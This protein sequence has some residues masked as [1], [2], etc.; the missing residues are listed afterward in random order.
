MDNSWDL[1]VFK[2]GFSIEITTFTDDLVEFDMVGIDPPLANAF[3]RILISEVPTVAI[4]RVTV[5]QNT[6]VIHDENLAH[7]LGLIPIR[8][9]PH[10][11]EWKK[12]D[13]E[14]DGS[15]SLVF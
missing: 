5:Y 4:S 3:R 15:N 1:A 8:F 12:S 14:F 7:R 9:D 6:G 13:E 11:L 2:K 10:E